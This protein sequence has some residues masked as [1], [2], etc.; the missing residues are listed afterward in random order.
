MVRRVELQKRSTLPVVKL[1]VV[2]FLS[3]VQRTIF[4]DG[5]QAPGVNFNAIHQA[6]GQKKKV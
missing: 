4:E 1:S 2:Q 3:E 5:N 6:T